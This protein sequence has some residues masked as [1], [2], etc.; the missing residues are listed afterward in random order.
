ML[1]NADTATYRAK[2]RGHACH[3]VFDKLVHARAVALLRQENDLWRAVD[4][5]VFPALRAIFDWVSG[6]LTAE[7]RGHS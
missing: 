7:A 3:E 2:A 4:C 6:G 5:G 1:R